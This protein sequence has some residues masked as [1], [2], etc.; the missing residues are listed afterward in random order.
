M[1]NSPHSKSIIKLNIHKCKGGIPSF[2][3]NPNT[4]KLE[5]LTISK[6]RFIIT[7]KL[8]MIKIEAKD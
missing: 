2:H 5:M 7:I 6:C 1:K 3:I 4:I 8:V